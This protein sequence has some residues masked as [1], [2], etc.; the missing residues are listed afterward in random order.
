MG[1]REVVAKRQWKL[2][3]YLNPLWL[4]LSRAK[5]LWLSF[6]FRPPPL[7]PPFWFFRRLW[8]LT[9]CVFNS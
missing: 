9:H 3:S 6:I 1:K 7:Y 5:A 8:F 4:R 2:A